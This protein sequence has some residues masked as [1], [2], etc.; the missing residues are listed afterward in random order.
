[1]AAKKNDT[2]ALAVTAPIEEDDAAALAVFG[3]FATDGLGD[4]DAD[5]LRLPSIV[6]NM[7]GKDAR[8]E[9]RR[10][11]EF[12]DTLNERTFRELRCAFVHL[13]KTNA[14]VRFDDAKNENVYICTSEDR[15]TGRLRA[16][17][18]S[19][20]IL[21]GTERKCDTCPDM[22][23]SASSDGKRK[24][25]CATHYGVFAVHLDDEL[26]PT[27]GF[28]AR[29]KRTSVE[30]LKT[31]M[32]KHHIGRLPLPGGKRGNVPFYGYEVRMR[33]EVSENGNY[34]LPVITR[35]RP[36]PRTTLAELSEQAK[37]FAELGDEATR[38]AEKQEARHERGDA[39]E[40]AGA[41]GGSLRADDFV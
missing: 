16:R 22:E 39:G 23:W 32:Q 10:L 37:F 36:L 28:F 20:P 40:S 7:K 18:P 26:R 38:A 1:M 9:L 29:F 33:L 25:N 2:A 24:K 19:L 11:D 30:P 12:Y 3:E 27:D 21:E 14:F 13:K 17:H 4:L 5:D 31:Y 6:W 41:S 8:G 15:V 35:G 34:A